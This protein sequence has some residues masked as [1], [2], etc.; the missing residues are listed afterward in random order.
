MEKKQTVIGVDPGKQGFIT[1]MKSTGI[2]H[3]PMPKVGKELD[4]H[5][6][7]ERNVRGHQ[8]EPRQ[9]RDVSACS[10]AVVPPTGFTSDGELHESR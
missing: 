4:L 5:E 3:Y 9:E 1:V 10:E 8:A 6:L 7:A 2:K